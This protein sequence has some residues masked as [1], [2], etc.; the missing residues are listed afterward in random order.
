MELLS[1]HPN[2][3]IQFWI[4]LNTRAQAHW[5][6]CILRTEHTLE[7]SHTSQCNEGL[8]DGQLVKCVRFLFVLYKHKDKSSISRTH[9]IKKSWASWCGASN[10]STGEVKTSRSLGTDSQLALLQARERPCLNEKTRWVCL[11]EGNLR[12]TFHIPAH[13]SVFTCMHTC[14]QGEEGR[15][16]G[17]D[18]ENVHWSTTEGRERQQVV[19][20]VRHRTM[21]QEK[22]LPT[23]MRRQSGCR[24]S[25]LKLGS[26]LNIQVIRNSEHSAIK[27]LKKTR[28][29]QKPTIQRGKTG[30]PL[31]GPQKGRRH[32]QKFSHQ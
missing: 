11:V 6:R 30:N 27:T 21:L 13:T 8:E 31:K 12:L 28:N 3:E 32:F 19:Y 17:R 9:I 2:G 10:L 4:H 7:A 26:S 24:V 5:P 16:G 15:E 14:T 25:F 22:L 18:G 1:V 20:G 23:S 29:T